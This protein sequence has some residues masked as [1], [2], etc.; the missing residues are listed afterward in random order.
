LAVFAH[1]L[2]DQQQN[3]RNRLLGKNKLNYLLSFVTVLMELLA[4]LFLGSNLRTVLL[5]RFSPR[6]L[7]VLATFRWHFLM[8]GISISF[9]SLIMSTETKYTNWL[10]YMFKHSICYV[11]SNLYAMVIEKHKFRSCRKLKLENQLS[12]IW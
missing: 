12:S 2:W 8:Y 5:R 6:S 4:L 7:K 3:L 11:N 10:I 1:Q 9:D